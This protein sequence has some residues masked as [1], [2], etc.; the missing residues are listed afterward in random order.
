MSISRIIPIICSRQV[1]QNELGQKVRVVALTT[2]GRCPH[3]GQPTSSPRVYGTEREYRVC[4]HVP[5]DP[6]KIWLLDERGD[7]VL[8]RNVILE[9]RRPPQVCLPLFKFQQI[10][11][12]VTEQTVD[13]K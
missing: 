4:L 10:F 8:L 9:G 6:R 5:S 12:P 1:W 3:R 13:T 11:T 7:P 2:G